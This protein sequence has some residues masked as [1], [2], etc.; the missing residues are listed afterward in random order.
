METKVVAVRNWDDLVFDSRNKEYGAYSLRQAYLRRL[1][2]GLGLST[3][4]IMAM[5]LMPKLFP[6]TN[7]IPDIPPIIFD[8]HKVTPPP[9]IIRN[10][11]IIRTPGGSRQNNN[12]TRTIVMVNDTSASVTE[13]NDIVLSTSI[14]G[15]GDAG[16][17]EGNGTALVVEDTSPVVEINRVLLTAQVM[18]A[19]GGGL[20]A[21]MKFIKKKLRYPVSARRQ[22]IEGTVFVSF[23][24]N[25]DGSV[26]DVAIVRGIHRDCDEEAKRVISMLPGWSGG[27]QNGSPVSVRMVLPIKFSMEH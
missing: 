18:P 2:L 24:V 19:Y 16:T 5:L 3:T 23:V 17:E 27:R 12:I 21:M 8:G 20:E 22:E 1:F 4:M 7:V 13:N 9:T 14:V 11:R 15:E 10:E 6:G 26:S 25:G